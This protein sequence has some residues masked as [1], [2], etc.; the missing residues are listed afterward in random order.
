MIACSSR[1]KSVERTEQT[2]PGNFE[3]E[4][5]VPNMEEE[6]EDE[7]ERNSFYNYYATF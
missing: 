5:L 2:D 3:E 4:E 6:S 7:G 1:K